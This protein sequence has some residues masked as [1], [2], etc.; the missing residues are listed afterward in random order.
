MIT[1]KELENERPFVP[2]R[3]E[4]R[5]PLHELISNRRSPRSY[6]GAPVEAWKIVTLF[7]AARWSPS[8]ANEQ[9]WH[10]I[11]ATKEDT[12]AYDALFGTLMEGNR[13]WASRAPMLVLGVAQSFY[14]KSG[15][16]YRHSWYDLGQSVAH[17]TLQATALGLAVHQMGGFDAEKA[18]EIFSIPDGYD[19]VVVL[20]AGYAESAEHLPD[21]LRS[22]ELAPRSRKSLEATVFTEKWGIP[23]HYITT[24][25]PLL[26]E[27]PSTN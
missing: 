4:Q 14:A 5:A 26:N 15:K 12:A 6:S 24:Q 2:Q 21:D 18:R 3:L 17:L 25:H 9:P 23:S 22:R 19:P 20:A 1:R 7:E 13:R 10:F 16:P 11:V 27:L 8:S